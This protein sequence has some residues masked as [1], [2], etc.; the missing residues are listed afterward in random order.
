[1]KTANDVCPLGISEDTFVAWYDETLG[2]EEARLIS[3]HMPTCEVCRSRLSEY[4]KLD[5]M[6]RRQRVPGVSETPWEDLQAGISGTGHTSRSSTR[7]HILETVGALAAAIL[8]IVGFLRVFQ[9]HFSG[10]GPQPTAVTARLLGTPTPLPTLGPSALPVPGTLP[11]WQAHTLPAHFEQPP[12]GSFLAVSASDGATAYICHAVSVS[13]GNGDQQAQIWVTHNF[14]TEWNHAGNLPELG[15]NPVECT[16][17]VDASDSQRLVAS[18]FALNP[19]TGVQ[20]HDWFASN[21]GGVTWTKIISNDIV[22][23]ATPASQ[24]P[25]IFIDHIATSQGKT[26]AIY[27]SISAWPT[28]VPTPTAAPNEPTNY[29]AVM[30]SH[31]EVSS[32]GLH[33]W[34]PVDEP[35]LALVGSTQYVTQFWSQVGAEGQMILLAEVGSGYQPHPQTLWESTDG[36]IHWSQLPAPQLNF[37]TAQAS[38]SNHS[39]YICGWLSGSDPHS[40]NML[41]TACSID[42]GKTW[43]ARPAIR[44]CESCSAQS[45]DGTDSYITSDGSL[46]APFQYQHASSFALYRLPPHSSEWQYLG[47]MPAK[48]AGAGLIYV[49]ALSSAVGGYLWTFYGSRANTSDLTTVIEGSQSAAA[50]FFTATLPA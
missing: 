9:S 21:D 3:D 43:S 41:V 48:D 42:G 33:T 50:M 7:R 20:V 30:D 39:W 34:Q 26:Y 1:M 36:G 29:P 22:I 23:T 15:S 19:T 47:Q 31:L 27:S 46:V 10:P 49:P 8:V 24:Q 44:T 32:D 4:T 16:L 17:D 45:L 12:L 28:N 35:I 2:N 5:Q 25:Q 37:F 40:V 38:G 11:S 13:G 6:L 18:F 14:G